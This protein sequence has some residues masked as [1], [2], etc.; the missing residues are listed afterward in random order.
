[1]RTAKVTSAPNRSCFEAPHLDLVPILHALP[2]LIGRYGDVFARTVLTSPNVSNTR[3]F[4]FS[5]ITHPRGEYLGK[6]Q[7][8]SNLYTGA[9]DNHVCGLFV[10]GLYTRY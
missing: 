1:M 9:G 2:P 8:L 3:W 4:F 7:R 6:R 5:V 10:Y